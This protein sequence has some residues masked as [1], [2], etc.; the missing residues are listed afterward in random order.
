MAPAVGEMG[1]EGMARDSGAPAAA[2][3][4]HPELQLPVLSDWT[5]SAVAPR[6]D[7]KTSNHHNP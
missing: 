4:R 3:P 1:P 5:L 7:A 2:S 6:K